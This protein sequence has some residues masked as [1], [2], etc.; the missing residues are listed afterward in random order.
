MTSQQ[1]TLLRRGLRRGML[2]LTRERGWWLSLCTLTGLLLLWQVSVVG[3][4]GVRGFEHLLTQ[5]T[6]L[7]L[8]VQRGADDQ[9]VQEFL[10]A[11]K[12]LPIIGR[13]EYVTREQALERE[14]LRS[15]D[16]VAFLEQF[17]V[18]NPFPD[19]IAVSL[20]KLDDYQAF[21]EFVREGKWTATINPG[22]LSQATTQQE[23]VENILSLT[24]TAKRGIALGLVL[25]GAVLF[26]MIT[27]F[28]RRRVHT[29]AD[30]IIVE[31][32]LGAKESSVL[33]PFTTESSILLLS[34]LGL[35]TL[36]LAAALWALP[37]MLPALQSGGI[38]WQLRHQVMYF[39][40]AFG[41]PLFSLE[42]IL[43]PVFAFFGSW[44]GVRPSRDWAILN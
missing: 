19:T 23:E 7:R 30:E 13:V 11:L 35:S 42:V 3:W 37:M 34:A 40:L 26:A 25:M 22:F 29:R 31:R 15:P 39:L 38:L 43:I 1:W 17:G 32:L 2:T 16:L 21:S 44:I 8:E 14:R 4:A 36:V 28:V 10:A 5:E 18:G 12:D 20:R 6:D 24:G 33:V 27:D 9:S 41:L